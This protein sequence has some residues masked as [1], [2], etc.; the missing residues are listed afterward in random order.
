MMEGRCAAE[1]WAEFGLLGK[2]GTPLVKCG[3][4]TDVFICTG[5]EE[6]YVFTAQEKT[7]R[8]S[9]FMFEVINSQMQAGKFLFL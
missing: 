9:R 3:T 7:L 1:P 4:G 8:V 5:G 2:S 6:V